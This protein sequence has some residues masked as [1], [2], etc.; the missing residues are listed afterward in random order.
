[1]LNMMIKETEDSVRNPTF[2]V[3]PPC[4]FEG[5][6]SSRSV[7]DGQ[8]TGDWGGFFALESDPDVKEK[9]NYLDPHAKELSTFGFHWHN[10]WNLPISKGSVADAVEKFYCILAALGVC[11]FG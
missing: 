1:M 2:H 7:V 11:D 10:R 9:L 8:K 6:L 5:A 3:L 4:F